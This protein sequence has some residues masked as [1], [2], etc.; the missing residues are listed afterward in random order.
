MWATDDDG[1]PT[2]AVAHL[3]STISQSWEPPM[4][5]QWAM[6]AIL[7]ESYDDNITRTYGGVVANG[8]MHMNEAQGSSGVNETNHWTI[9]GD[10]SLLIRTSPSSAAAAFVGIVLIISL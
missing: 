1:N 7:T 8:C 6:N 9:F 5:G 2:G 10:P 3:G 4:H